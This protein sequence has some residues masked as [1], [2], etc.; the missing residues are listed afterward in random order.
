MGCHFLLKGG[1]IVNSWIEK[2]EVI[3]FSPFE[4]IVF[5]TVMFRLSCHGSSASVLLT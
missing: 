1:I 2:T 3:Y 5:I 4:A